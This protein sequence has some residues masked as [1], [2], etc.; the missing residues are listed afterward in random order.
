MSFPSDIQ[1][2]QA[3][4]VV[5]GGGVIAYPTEAVWGL[6]CDPFNRD[7]VLRLLEIKQRPMHK[8]LIIIAAEVA[9]V[10]PWLG[11]LT[12]RQ[13]RRVIET[14]PGPHTW[15]VPVGHDFPEWVRGDH[16]SVAVRVSAHPVVRALCRRYGGALVST[17]AN[18][19]GLPPA[20]SPLQVRC[21]LR[22]Q[23]DYLLPGRLGGQNKP[24]LIRDALTG[25]VLRPS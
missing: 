2:R 6:G 12:V 7:A 22:G 4:R 9:Q 3:V 8:G 14:W 1:L 11:G 17:S 23:V 10:L 25:Q 18:R 15:V 19:T 20:R 16:A 5:D 13:C 24:T 21:G